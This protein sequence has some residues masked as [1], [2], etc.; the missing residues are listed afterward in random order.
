MKHLPTATLQGTLTAYAVY[1]AHGA[2]AA[3]IATDALT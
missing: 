1:S 3:E 2:A